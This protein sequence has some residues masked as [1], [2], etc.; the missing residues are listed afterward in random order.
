MFISHQTKIYKNKVM[1]P[2]N[3]GLTSRK[4]NLFVS[5]EKKK[6]NPLNPQEIP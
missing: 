1:I 3:I 6:K 4:Q 2:T 5:R